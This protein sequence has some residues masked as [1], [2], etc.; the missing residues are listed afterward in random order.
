MSTFCKK[1]E[2]IADGCPICEAVKAEREKC[3]ELLAACKSALNALEELDDL[4]DTNTWGI[5]EKLQ[6]V[7]DKAEGA[8]Y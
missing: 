6:T 8:T 2:P 5:Q 1:H 3:T 7:I 4:Q